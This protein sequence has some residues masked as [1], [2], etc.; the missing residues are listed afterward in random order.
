MRRTQVTRIR[1][2]FALVLASAVVFGAC[3]DDD[4]SSGAI[5]PVVGATINVVATEQPE[6]RLLAE[7]YAQ[8][9]EN[10]GFRIGRKDPVA[11]RAAAYQKLVD[12]SAQFTPEFTSSLLS[13][14]SADQGKEVP[15]VAGTSE[16]V[17][18]L[19]DLLPDTL[20]IGD[21]SSVSTTGSLACSTAA[22]DQYGLKTIGDLVEHAAEVR[23]AGPAGF[24]TATPW[25][26]AGYGTVYGTEFTQFVEVAPDGV[27]GAITSGKADC[28]ALHATDPA[29]VL[30]GL[31]TLTDD[32]KAVPDDLTVPLM[33]A[34][35]ASPEVLSTISQI[36]ATLTTDV[37]RALLVK[38]TQNGG[39]YDLVVAEYIAAQSLSDAG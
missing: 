6:S 38:V 20:V 36:D 39:S 5:V 26:L 10:A 11:D 4:S 34:V 27:A 7:I 31:L 18:A 24:D 28:G 3:G 25:G 8:G 37:I 17:T 23:I 13:F 9:L 32:R 22:V 12:D 1:S 30:D 35:A 21:P 33:S 15:A 19:N 16:T 14:L 2:T 29:G